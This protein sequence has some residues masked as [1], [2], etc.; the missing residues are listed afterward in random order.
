MCLIVLSG[1]QIPSSYP[2]CSVVEIVESCA[3]NIPFVKV[4]KLPNTVSNN[5]FPESH[6]ICNY[7][8]YM[9]TSQLDDSPIINVYYLGVLGEII[10]YKWEHTSSI[11]K[12]VKNIITNKYLFIL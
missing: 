3:L 9:A 1:T 11:D 8:Y 12:A 7:K 5:C 6:G 10:D 4:Y 2:N